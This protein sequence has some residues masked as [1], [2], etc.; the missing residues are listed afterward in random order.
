MSVIIIGNP[1]TI[2]AHIISFNPNIMPSGVVVLKHNGKTIGV[3]R[4]V[5]GSVSFILQSSVLG[6]GIHNFITYYAG[7]D[8]FSASSSAVITKNIV[9]A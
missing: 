4:I 1:I 7:D 5:S 8:N 2:T 9:A 6:I 3:E